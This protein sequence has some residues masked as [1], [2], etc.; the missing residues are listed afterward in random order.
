MGT[1]TVGGSIVVM[2]APYSSGHL[3][4]GEIQSQ[5][6]RRED[7]LAENVSADQSPSIRLQRILDT[8]LTWVLRC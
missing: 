1:L 8:N 4:D 3:V 5:T 2:A 6:G 7:V